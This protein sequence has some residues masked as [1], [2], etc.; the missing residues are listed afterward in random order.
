MEVD[1]KLVEYTQELHKAIDSLEHGNKSD[2][3]LWLSNYYYKRAR[4][5][6]NNYIRILQ[7]TV[8]DERYQNADPQIKER[9]ARF[10]Y[11][12]DTNANSET[13]TV[14]IKRTADGYIFFEQVRSN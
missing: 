2:A 5:K 11:F 12:I 6:Q 13:N 3:E 7:W 14:F 10:Y 8:A 9:I 4:S 1:V